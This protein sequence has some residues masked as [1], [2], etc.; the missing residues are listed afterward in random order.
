MKSLSHA[1]AL[2]ALAAFSGCASQAGKAPPAPAA[3]IA[4]LG[5]EA[6]FERF[7]YTGRAQEQVQMQP[8]AF[9]NP[10]LSGYYP[11]PSIT[12]VG[13]DY[14][15]V[16]SSFTNFPGLPIFHSRDLTQWTQVGNAIDRPGQFNFTGLRSSR[17]IF[18]PDISHHNGVYYIVTTCVDCGG[19]VVMTASRPEGPWSDPKRIPFEGIDPSIFWDTDGKAWIVNNGAPN[20]TP[21]YDGHR[22]IWVQQFD[23]RTLSMVGERT[24]LV[25]GGVD[26]ARKPIW[27]EGPHLLKR[28]GYYYLIAAEGGTGDQ[29]SQVVFRSTGVRGPFQPYAR[30]PILS[31][32]TLDPRRA[33]PV[34]SAG[35]AKFV[36]TQNGEWW[37]TFLATRPYENGMYNIGRET[38]L[39]PVSWKDD[40]PMIL[41]DGLRIPF[42]APAPNLPAQARPALPLSGDF[43]Y[44][45]EFDG[46]VLAAPWI[47]VRTPATPFHKLE[48]GQLVLSSAG[49]LGDLKNTP[50]FLARRQQHHIATVGTRLRFSPGQD[51]ERAGLVAYQSDESYLFFG[52][53]RS[54]G[55][56]VVALYLRAKGQ[57]EVLVASAP[58]SGDE[59]GLTLSAD[60]GRMNFA[61]STGAVPTTLKENV[62]VTFLSTQKAGGFVGTI[63]GPYVWRAPR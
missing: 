26:L 9:R 53:T 29:H 46:S 59:I 31:Q 3:A 45:D 57:D 11:D 54:G 61:Y 63:I 13:A 55:Q 1:A 6:R 20:E 32:R 21:R 14:Y 10:I 33:N 34:T 58:V 30:N 8:G 22:A 48:Q 52:L 60:G 42:S 7:T 36:Q 37:A 39:L 5:A 49:R 47:G 23:P 62:D 41:E 40:W 43:G 2:L 18:A 12:R 4:P 24:Q 38:F 17:G 25:N 35:H 51:G 44:V 28:G 15:L 16:N 50:A 27:I 56:S 19:N